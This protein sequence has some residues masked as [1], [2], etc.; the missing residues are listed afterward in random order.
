MEQQWVSIEFEFNS[1][2]FGGKDH[3]VFINTSLARQQSVTHSLARF[4]VAF[5][6][7]RYQP[8]SK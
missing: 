6:A 4:T 8:R 2:L 7:P 3:Y 1:L 5:L